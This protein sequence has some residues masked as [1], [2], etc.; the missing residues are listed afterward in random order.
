M[1]VSYYPRG[2]VSIIG[3]LL[4]V[5]H[6]IHV[7][8][9]IIVRIIQQV[10]RPCGGHSQECSEQVPILEYCGS[11]LQGLEDLR[12]NDEVMGSIPGVIIQ[13]ILLLHTFV[14]I[15]CICILYQVQFSTQRYMPT[16]GLAYRHMSIQTLMQRL[17][18]GFIR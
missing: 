9:P 12:L 13:Y 16:V 11:Q 6:D 1:L 14:S 4:Y 5:Q 18:F 8:V 17:D 3:L 7:T 15:N 2:T 10:P